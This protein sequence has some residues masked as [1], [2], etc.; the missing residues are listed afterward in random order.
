MWM[1]CPKVGCHKSVWVFREGAC[2]VGIAANCVQ[3]PVH[4]SE[5]EAELLPFSKD[6]VVPGEFSQILIAQSMQLQ[7]NSN[8]EN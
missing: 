4:L 6:M 7:N 1:L 3:E 2:W 8:E 5:G